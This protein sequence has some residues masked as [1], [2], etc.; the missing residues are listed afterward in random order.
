MISF[1]KTYKNY[2]WIDEETEEYVLEK[3]G[4]VPSIEYYGNYLDEAQQF[5]GTWEMV[6]ESNRIMEGEYQESIESGRWLM[7]ELKLYH[8]NIMLN[9]NSD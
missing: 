5:E 4:F 8:I 3:G 2:F 1:T 7:K 9:R 6:L